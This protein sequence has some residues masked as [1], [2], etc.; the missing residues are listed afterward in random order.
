VTPAHTVPYSSGDAQT[1]VSIGNFYVTN[2]TWNIGA[3]GSQ[4][5]YICDY[6][7]WFAMATEPGTTS[8]KSYPNV[9]QDF[10]NWGSGAMPRIS[11]YHSITSS[12]AETSPHSGIYEWA[13]DIWLN[14]VADNNST[15]IMIWNDNF[16][17]FPAGSHRGTF[18]SGGRTY[19]VY[20]DGTSCAGGCYIAFVAQSN[21]T[22]G[23]VD[24]L[25][26]FN[27]VIGTQHW[28]DNTATL[29]QIDYGVEICST[30]SVS[31]KF[32]LNNFSLV[33]Q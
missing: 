11:N 15:E 27:Y 22:S 1:G 23:S 20:S 19:D 28:L 26:F 13:Y 24:I 31:T 18:A 4:T 17:Q 8:V 21:F 7:N 12:F 32:E 10:I 9:H 33:A 3:S 14:G 5:M 30:N 2:D 16:H 25:A 29:G 6:N